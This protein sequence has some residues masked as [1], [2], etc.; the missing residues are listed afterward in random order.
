MVFPHK[1]NFNLF[2]NN[3][4]YVV[5]K[6]YNEYDERSKIKRGIFY[7]KSFTILLA[8]INDVKQFVNSA[9]SHSCDIDLV[10]GRYIIDAKSIMGI[11]SIDLAKPITVEIHGSDA[12]ADSFIESIKGYIIN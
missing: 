2:I 1:I 6:Y 9:C 8:S 4:E 10:S 7:M 3:I 12:E 5:S 11:F